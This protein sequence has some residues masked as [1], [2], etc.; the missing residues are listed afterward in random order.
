MYH[1][2]DPTHA[3]D[4]VGVHVIYTWALQQIGV[5]ND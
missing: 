1:L 2:N 3:W 4:M 5:L